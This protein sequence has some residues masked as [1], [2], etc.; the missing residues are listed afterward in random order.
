MNALRPRS[1]LG[2]SLPDGASSKSGHVRDTPKAEEARSIRGCCDMPLRVDVGALN[3]ISSQHLLKGDTVPI[4]SADCLVVAWRGAGAPLHRAEAP[5]SRLSGSSMKRRQLVT[6][7]VI[8]RSAL[9]L[10]LR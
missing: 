9:G 5:V 8:L 7:H 6:R 3:V 1:G 2:Q 10:R 4:V